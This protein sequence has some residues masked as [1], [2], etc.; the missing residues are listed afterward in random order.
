MKWS[1][2][3]GSGRMFFGCYEHNLDNKGRLFIPSKFRHELGTLVYITKGLDGCLAIYSKQAFE[4]KLE[5]Y[6]SLSF[7]HAATRAHLR[8]N[9]AS[10]E[11]LNVDAQGRLPIPSRLLKKEGIT[12]AITIVGVL[13]HIEVWDREHWNEY[14]E[15]NYENDEEIVETLDD[16]KSGQE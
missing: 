12:Q 2:V 13:D 6:K 11:E 15:N 16:R 1:K 5:E 14:Y 3:E 7:N 10:F 4:P 9:V 8:V